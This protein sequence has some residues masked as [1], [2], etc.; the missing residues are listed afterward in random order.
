MS[1]KLNS[2][3]TKKKI[4]LKGGKGF[5]NTK[6][7]DFS[8]ITVVKNSD[9]SI[10][11]TIRSVL[12]Q[13]KVTFEYIIIDGNSSDNTLR[14]IKRFNKKIN[15]WCSVND[16][17]IYDAMNIGLKLANERVI[18]FV[19]SDDFFYNMYALSKVKKYFDKKKLIIF[20]EL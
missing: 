12:K 19:N 9:K 6:N 2:R 17:G 11:K 1:A 7:Y 14:K 8:I 5:K 18:C 20:L 15:Y 10:E 3:N 4:I 13:K 16:N